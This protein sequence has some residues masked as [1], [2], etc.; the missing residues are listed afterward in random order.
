[1]VVLGDTVN[2]MFTWFWWFTAWLHWHIGN[3]GQGSHSVSLIWR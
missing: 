1:M 3:E 2:R